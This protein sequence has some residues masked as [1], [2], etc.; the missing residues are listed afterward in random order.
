MSSLLSPN[1]NCF[2]SSIPES[3]GSQLRAAPLSRFACVFY[4]SCNATRCGLGSVQL[5][6][7]AGQGGIF[8]IDALLRSSHLAVSGFSRGPLLIVEMK[9]FPSFSYWDF[10]FTSWNYF[11]DCRDRI[12]KKSGLE[13][14]WPEF[15]F[16]SAHFC[17]AITV[18]H[19]WTRQM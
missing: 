7:P 16:H 15:E 19:Q 11:F 14:R 17:W 12:R 9:R 13:A 2:M 4:W 8:L 6:S 10:L 5:H 3:W 1:G 18:C